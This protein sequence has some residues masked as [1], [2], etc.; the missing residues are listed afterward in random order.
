MYP[1]P[2]LN[3]PM[4]NLF[5]FIYLYLWPSVR[6]S[7]FFICENLFKLF[8]ENSFMKISSFLSLRIFK[9]LVVVLP[10]LRNVR[11]LVVIL[12]SCL[13][14]LGGDLTKT[15]SNAT[16]LGEWGFFM[17]DVVLQSL[18]HSLLFLWCYF[19]F[20]VFWRHSSPWDI[21]R[22]LNTFC[23]FSP[24]HRWVIRDTF[25]LTFLDTTFTVLPGA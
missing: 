25:I 5:L 8:Y 22:F 4:G 15:H 14:R 21:A 16:C 18:I 10:T 7:S 9:K 6:I 20:I 1:P 19:S 24:A 12:L 13:S 17:L 23:T 3:P 11:V 2:P